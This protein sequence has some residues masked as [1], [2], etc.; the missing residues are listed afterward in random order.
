MASEVPFV[1]SVPHQEL[2]VA[3]AGLTVIMTARWNDRDRAFYLDV[4]ESD[5]TPIARGLKVVLGVKLGRKSTHKF[6]VGRALFAVDN[7]NTGQECGIDDLGA[8]V[9]ILY[10]DE[11]DLE[12]ASTPPFAVPR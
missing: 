3:I 6:F 12:L 4:F 1:P 11:G 2:E 7:S 8:R 10:L 9:S 5:N